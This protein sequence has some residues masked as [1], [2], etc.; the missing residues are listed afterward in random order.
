M[1]VMFAATA[2]EQRGCSEDM[3]RWL[4]EGKLTPRIDRVMPLSN[5]AEAHR[6]QEENTL[7][8]AGTLTGKIVLTP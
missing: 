7:G 2:E 4:G 5:A 1:S 8:A 3:N 6:L